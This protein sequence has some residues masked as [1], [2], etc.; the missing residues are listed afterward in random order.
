MK[1]PKLYG[2]PNAYG[3]D[4]EGR[5]RLA[6]YARA[7]SRTHREPGQHVGPITRAHLDVLNGLMRIANGHTG[8][9]F[10]SYDHIA[11]VARVARSTVAGAIKSLEAAGVIRVYNRIKR[12]GAKVLT[13]SNAYVF[14]V[15]GSQSENPTGT[16]KAKESEIL[17][18]VRYVVL[19]PKNPL[20]AVLARLGAAI[21][22]VSS[23]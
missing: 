21:G 17:M 6:M 2:L 1:R 23:G 10:P 5:V 7:W 18:P 22:A 15:E 16:P 4:R 11:K 9:C 20:D 3:L 8:S 14:R 19:D 12:V 13:T